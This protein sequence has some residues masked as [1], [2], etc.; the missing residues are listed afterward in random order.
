MTG[1]S[2]SVVWPRLAA[3]TQ[4]RVALGRS[5]ADQPT[6]TALSFALD[7]A[8]ARQAVGSELNTDTLQAALPTP[9][10]LVRSAARDRAEYLQRPDLGRYL[11]SATQLD[12]TPGDLLIVIGD[13]LSAMAVQAHAAAVDR[14]LLSRICD[15]GL[16][17]NQVVIATQA[18]VAL[19][20]DVARATGARAVVMLVGERPGLSAADSL[21]AYITWEPDTDTPNARRNCVSNIRDGGLSHEEAVERLIFLLRAMRETGQS[22][23]ALTQHLGAADAGKLAP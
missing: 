23:V 8:R 21:G 10:T 18:R 2:L 13:G 1:K 3:R 5:G 6:A 7:H 14:L 12:P 15:A 22:G 11:S 17:L 20:D 16:S 19:G 4:A 9:V